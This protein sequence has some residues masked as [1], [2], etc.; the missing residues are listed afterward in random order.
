V[1]RLTDTK[2]FYFLIEEE[3]M[4]FDEPYTRDD[5]SVGYKTT[6]VFKKP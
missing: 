4:S 5:G 3:L 1:V 6:E 2:S